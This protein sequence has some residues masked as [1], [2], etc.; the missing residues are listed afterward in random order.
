MANDCSRADEHRAPLNVL[1]ITADQLRADALGCY[2]NQV[3]ATPHIDALARTGMCFDQVFTACPA[4]APN[5]AALCTGRYPSTNGVR[6]NGIP[7]PATELTMMEVLRRQG[8]RTYAAG[9]MHFGPQ[10]NYPPNGD[11]LKD[12]G[13]ELAVDPQPRPEE[14][15]WHGFERVQITE[16]HRIGPYGRYLRK[17][18]FDPWADPHSF[19]YPQS[20][21]ARSVYPAK[22]HQT[23]WIA[24]RG[25]DFIREHDAA[26]PF[27]AWVSFVHPHHPFTPPAPY[28]KTYDP[29]DMP[30]PVRSCVEQ[31]HWP[32]DYSLKFHARSGSHEAVGMS[33]FDDSQWQ[34]I[35][36]FYYGMVSQIDEQVGRLIDMLEQRQLRERTIVV[37]T[38]DHG[39]MLGDHGLLFKGCHFDQ[40]TRMPLIISRPN[41]QSCGQRHDALASAIDLM[42]TLLDL[43]GVASPPHVQGRSMTPAF[44]SLDWAGRGAVLIEHVSKLRTIRTKRH[45]LSWHGCGEQGELYDLANDPHC[46]ENLWAVPDARELR[47]CLTEHLIELMVDH[48]DPMPR[49]LAPC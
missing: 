39:E 2:G 18:G 10:W 19:T 23:T 11:K 7:L 17:H 46:F 21:C 26:K 30:L 9:K 33:G 20:I 22:H 47:Q 27:F 34:T 43:C 38:A 35:K 32:R 48:V 1:L 25:L 13:T 4:C 41:G 29:D 40:V 28:D 15:P 44:D 49:R 3:V 42:P 24:N 45:Q 37:F 31:H 36:A 8:Y 6:L 12:P 14:M 16:D 5:R